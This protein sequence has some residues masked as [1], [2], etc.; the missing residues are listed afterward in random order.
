MSKMCI[1]G[2]SHSLTMSDGANV[3]GV[4]FISGLVVPASYWLQGKFVFDDHGCLTIKQDSFVPGSV[5][6][7]WLDIL[8]RNY[9]QSLFDLNI[10]IVT[11]LPYLVAGEIYSLSQTYTTFADKDDGKIFL[12]SAAY[13]AMVFGRRK[14]IFEMLKTLISRGVDVHVVVVP[15]R[16]GP[17]DEVLKNNAMIDEVLK[18]LGVKIHSLADWATDDAG[19]LLPK[20][21]CNY[22]GDKVHANQDFAVEVM[23]RLC[24][25]LGI[26]VSDVRE[27][28]IPWYV[29][30][31]K[32][33]ASNKVV[34]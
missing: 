22:E 16:I 7:E 19:L 31:P 20:Y 11:T 27:D 17:I 32:T 18:V 8:D 3:L 33:K 30:I 14:R 6:Q 21:H 10:P 25:T 26:P 23:R 9:K 12:S 29:S 34:A 28:F 13:R 24:A 5:V 15:S 4:P 1:L 2:D